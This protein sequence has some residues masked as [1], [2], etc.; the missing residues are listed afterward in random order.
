MSDKLTKLTGETGRIYLV[1]PLPK[2]IF[3]FYAQL[4][5]R[6]SERA[7]AALQK[8]DIAA[9][10]QEALATMDHGKLAKM[11]E[12]STKAVTHVMVN[13]RI[14]DDPKDETEISPFDITEN[15]FSMLTAW[16]M[17]G[18]S[19]GQA[20]GLDSF[21]TRPESTAANRSNGKKLRK[22]AK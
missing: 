12:F 20:E 8:G 7:M 16:A 6:F 10:G 22:A 18:I 17:H 3:L 14:A 21:R 5:T 4:P 15:D 2:H 19:G 9:L 1:R 11:I 13:P